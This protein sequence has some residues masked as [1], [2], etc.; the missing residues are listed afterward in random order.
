VGDASAGQTTLTAPITAGAATIVVADASGIS[1]GDYLQIG[2]EVLLCGAPSGLSVPVTRAQLGSVAASAASGAS[3]WLVQQRVSTVSVPL[4]FVNSAA[5]EDWVLYLPLP[6]MKLLSVG[7]SV[8]N[9]YGESQVNFVCLT[10]NA[11]HGM[12]LASS[13]NQDRIVN[14]TNTDTALLPGNQFVSVAA[15]TRNTTITLPSEAADV[16]YHVTVKRA[17]GS[18]FNVIVTPGSGDT[19]GGSGASETMSGTEETKTWVGV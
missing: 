3:A 8:T 11:D 18:T 19:I 4:D 9:A 17:A 5:I 10:G 1:A 15:T 6:D 2:A 7:G 16:G 14:V 12:R 13:S